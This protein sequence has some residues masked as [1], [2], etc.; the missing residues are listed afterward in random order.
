[1]RRGQRTT[2]SRERANTKWAQ[3]LRC[4]TVL[5]FGGSLQGSNPRPPQA[6][7]GRKEGSPYFSAAVSVRSVG[8]L[9]AELES[10]ARHYVNVA[11]LEQKEWLKK[12][13]LT[14]IQD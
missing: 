3:Q 6:R 5:W 8:R 7:K 9:E 12:H 11:L 4:D 14:P 13:K 1:M 2:E 10:V